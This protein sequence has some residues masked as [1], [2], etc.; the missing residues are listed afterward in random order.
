ME[1]KQKIESLKY[2]ELGLKAFPEHKQTM[3]NSAILIQEL[4][5]KDMRQAAI[6]RLKRLTELDRTS[7]K[8]YFGLGL[9]YMDEKRF[10]DASEA[11]K[12][13]IEVSNIKF[14]QRN[15]QYFTMSFM[16]PLRLRQIS[17]ALSLIWL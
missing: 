13:S 5:I 2:F 15:Y 14:A 3:Y 8:P 6:Q 10:D 16:C 9:L 1:K 11:Y 7:P 17:A 4:N 12:K